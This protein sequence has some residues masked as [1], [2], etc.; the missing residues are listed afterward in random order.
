MNI[1]NK[2]LIFI[3]SFV[4]I[5][6]VVMIFFLVRKTMTNEKDIDINF[7][8]KND[9][10]YLE[11]LSKEVQEKN[12]KAKTLKSF[13]PVDDIKICDYKKDCLK[14]IFNKC[15][16]GFGLFFV[17]DGTHILNISRL[18]PNNVCDFYI[19]NMEEAGNIYCHIDKNE[20][21]D[22]LFDEIIKSGVNSDFLISDYKCVLNTK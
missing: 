11:K 8:V 4:L 18:N 17:E 12:E 22:S 19:A 14:D 6:L 21:D 9:S 15:I 20:L 2:Y 1:K 16:T 7:V 5:V 10:A 13:E 3:S